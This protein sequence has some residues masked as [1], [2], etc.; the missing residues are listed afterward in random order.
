MIVI[1]EKMNCFFNLRCCCVS[2]IIHY[3]LVFP[4]E[5]MVVFSAVISSLV[6][7]G[8]SSSYSSGVFF[9]SLCK[10]SYRQRCSFALRVQDLS[11]AI[12]VYVVL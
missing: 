8:I 4:V 3:F 11:H 6:S 7:S 2:F 10:C 1:A 12:K 9:S 5:V